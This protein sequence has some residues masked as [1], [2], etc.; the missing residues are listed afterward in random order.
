MLT[1]AFLFYSL[2]ILCPCNLYFGDCSSCTYIAY[3][4]VS[5]YEEGP[6]QWRLML[7]N[8]HTCMS[9]IIILINSRG[10]CCF[11]QHFAYRKS[12]QNNPVSVLPEVTS[13]CCSQAARNIFILNAIFCHLRAGLL[14]NV[15]Y[16]LINL[17]ST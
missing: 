1:F 4:N 12:L 17:Y 13:S 9:I 14:Y 5:K 15:Y 7:H 16:C 10:K 8:V 2:F 6:M 3:Y 11:P